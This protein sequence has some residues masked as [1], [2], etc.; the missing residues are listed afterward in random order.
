M[1][2][3]LIWPSVKHTEYLD[4]HKS[5]IKPV[6]MAYIIA[7]GF[8]ISIIRFPV[9]EDMTSR[10]YDSTSVGR[11]GHAPLGIADKP[12]GSNLSRRRTVDR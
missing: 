10:I 6:I 12:R 5:I 4:A 1:S 8:V 9:P 7:G 2:L 11:V 3:A